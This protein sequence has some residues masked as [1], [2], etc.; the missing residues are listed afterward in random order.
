LKLQSDQRMIQQPSKPLAQFRDTLRPVLQLYA[1]CS[2]EQDLSWYLM[3]GILSREAAVSVA[4]LRSKLVTKVSSISA[5][6]IESFDI[7]NEMLFAPI[8]KDWVEYN[9]VDNQG[10]IS[11]SR[12]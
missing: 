8:A 4:T 10:E 5:A 6:L 9:S 3:Q 12:I 7:P 2:I 11:A 1:M